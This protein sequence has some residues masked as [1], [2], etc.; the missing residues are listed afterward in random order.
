M[1]PARLLPRLR[2]GLR[3]VTGRRLF[4]ALATCLLLVQTG[5]P[6]HQDSHPLGYPDTHCQYCVMAGHLFSVPVVTLPPPVAPVPADRPL[7]TL[8]EFQ[9]PALPRTRFSRAPPSLSIA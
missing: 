3:R 4:L 9:I 7:A 6:A 5:L 1:K 8:V 2:R